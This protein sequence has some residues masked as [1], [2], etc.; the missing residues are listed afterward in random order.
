MRGR[1]SADL[2]ERT[3]RVLFGRLD[4]FG[5]QLVERSQ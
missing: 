3:V 4:A 5:R 1:R 2:D